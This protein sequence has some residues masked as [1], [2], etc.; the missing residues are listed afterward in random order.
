MRSTAM[1]KADFITA[2]VF[3]AIGVLMALAGTTMPGPAEVS[4]IEAGGEPGRVPI[5]L[6]LIIA[7]FS[8]IL[9]I[10]SV[11]QGGHRL[12]D[13]EPLEPDTRLG[14]KRSVAA[15]LGCSVYAVG[16]V[17]LSIAGW[18]VPYELATGLFI[19]LFI[20]GFEWQ[21]AQELA[22]KR[23][24]KIKTNRPGLAKWI[25]HLF[26]FVPAEQGPILWLLTTAF[27]QAVIATALI[28]YLFEKNFYVTLP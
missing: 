4:Y 15:A 14:I 7:G 27:L 26:A 8:L 18:K 22:E 12:T 1:A 28:T 5:L 16:L 20:V 10:R 19:F 9:L 17:G 3:F 11:A 13:T 2:L 6:G 24:Q 23:W 21:M 25:S